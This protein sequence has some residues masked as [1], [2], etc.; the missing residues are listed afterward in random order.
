MYWIFHLPPSQQWSHVALPSPIVTSLPYG[1][2]VTREPVSTK[3]PDAACGFAVAAGLG[4]AHF[5]PADCVVCPARYSV[6]L[7]GR[8]GR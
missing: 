8:P 6:G 3:L 4:A 5:A 1:F 7:P 2:W